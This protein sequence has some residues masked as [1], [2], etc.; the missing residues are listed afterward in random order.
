MSKKCKDA[1]ARKVQA[2]LET[3]YIELAHEEAERF[4]WSFQGYADDWPEPLNFPD[5]WAEALN[6]WYRGDLDGNRLTN[7]GGYLDP[8]GTPYI[9]KYF[10]KEKRIQIHSYGPNRTDDK[11]IGDD[12]KAEHSLEW[13]H[14]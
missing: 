2:E 5:K 6:L 9:L 12:I 8:W 4:A 3:T 14:R 10:S 7:D 1:E 13:P 11:G